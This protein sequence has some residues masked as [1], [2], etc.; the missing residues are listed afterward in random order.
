MK[1][2]FVTHANCITINF[3]FIN[4]LLRWLQQQEFIDDHMTWW[5]MKIIL[6]RGFY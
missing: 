4:T 1:Y 3:T 6:E 2:Q 5:L